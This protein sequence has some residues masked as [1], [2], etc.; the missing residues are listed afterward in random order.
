MGEGAGDT[1]CGN[2]VMTSFWFLT[3]QCLATPQMYHFFPGIAKVI[4]SLPLVRAS[5]PAGAAHCLKPVPLTLRTLWAPS[6][7]LKTA[8]KS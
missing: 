7:Y 2:T 3:S 8:P 1:V 4:T 5:V 6:L